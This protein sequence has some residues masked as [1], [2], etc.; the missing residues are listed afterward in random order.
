MAELVTLPKMA[1][2]GIRQTVPFATRL[3]EIPKVFEAMMEIHK[4]AGI[5]VAGPETALYRVTGEQMEVW[6]GVPM[7]DLLPGYEG[8]EAPESR[9]LVIRHRGPFSELPEVY[10]RLWAAAE[11]QGLAPSGL[12]REVYRIIAKDPARNVCDVYLDVA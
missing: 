11:A 1:L 7:D 8:F 5:I 6:V 4:A 3:E 12:A 10:P 9:A 2:G